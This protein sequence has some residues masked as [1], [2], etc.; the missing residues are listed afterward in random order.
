MN[1]LSHEPKIHISL[2]HDPWIQG[3]MK[4]IA[5]NDEFLIRGIV[6]S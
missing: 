5:M 3:I 1:T 2:I 6:T 4:M